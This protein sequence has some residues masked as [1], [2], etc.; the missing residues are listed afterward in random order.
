M[1]N[2]LILILRFILG[3]SYSLRPCFSIFVIITFIEINFLIK[4]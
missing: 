2:F 3:S 1:L 4:T